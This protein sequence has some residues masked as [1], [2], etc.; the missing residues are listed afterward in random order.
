M[1]I[2]YGIGM[3]EVKPLIFG[4]NLTIISARDSQSQHNSLFKA[5][6]QNLVSIPHMKTVKLTKMKKKKRSNKRKHL[7]LT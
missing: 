5:E 2:I 7:I 1:T 3:Y 6:V 4:Q